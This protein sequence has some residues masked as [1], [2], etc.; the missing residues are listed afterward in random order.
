MK[1]ILS[2]LILVPLLGLVSCTT[3]QK[4]ETTNNSDYSTPE[5]EGISSGAIL[6]FVEALETSQTD[7]IHSVM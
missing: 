4:G 3:S 5:A 6:K 1:K 7:A 2:I